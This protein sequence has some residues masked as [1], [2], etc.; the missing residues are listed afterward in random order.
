MLYT[1]KT[2]ADM[3]TL[4]S[5]ESNILDVAASEDIDLGVKLD[6]AAEQVGDEIELWLR[7]RAPID[8]VLVTPS[9]RQWHAMQT[10]ELVYRDAY[11]QEM[12]DRYKMKWVMYGELRRESRNRCFASG[13]SVVSAPVPCGPK[14]T[15]GT[16]VGGG[17]TGSVYLR[18]TWASADGREGAPGQLQV[19]EN[20]DGVH[21][22]AWVD[23]AGPAECGWNVYAGTAPDELILQN[24]RILETGEIWAQAG[25][26]RATGREIH[27]GQMADYRVLDCRRLPRG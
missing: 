5:Y 8:A 18:A 16:G 22:V 11:Y 13:I 19:F 27:A 15:L 20:Q 17:A 1:D 4:E 24:D 9:V 2:P 23:E 7:N 21:L 6:L 10:L 14:P 12:N 25:P 3:E 26:L